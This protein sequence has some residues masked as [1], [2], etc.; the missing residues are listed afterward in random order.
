MQSPVVGAR[1]RKT[2]CNSR[3]Y[4]VM[5][6]SRVNDYVLNTVTDVKMPVQR[7]IGRRMYYIMYEILCMSCKDI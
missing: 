7:A 6:V 2:Y 1:L 5:Q 3:D 4:S